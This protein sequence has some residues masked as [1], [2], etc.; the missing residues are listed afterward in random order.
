MKIAFILLCHKNSDQI[1]KLLKQLKKFDCEI[2]LHC[3]TK[4]KDIR[5]N[6]MKSNNVHI[7]SEQD[8]YD[9]KWGGTEMIF[10][11]LSL[12]KNVKKYSEN[13]NIK[14][15]YIW[16]LSGQDY[17]IQKPQFIIKK[18]QSNPQVNYLNI[19]P[20]NTKKYYEYLKR[21]EIK[22]SNPGWITKNTFIIKAIKYLYL[23]VTGGRFHTFK[24]FKRKKTFDGEFYFGSQWWTITDDCAN[25]ILKF[26]E[27]HEEYIEFFEN[28]IV[29]DECFF[30]TI[31]MN[32]CFKDSV[33]NNLT[34]VNWGNNNRSP[35]LITS[36]KLPE[37][38]KKNNEY[39]FARKFD[40]SV[41]S[42]ILDNVD[43]LLEKNTY[44]KKK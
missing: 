26:C 36:S 37:I 40:T 9:I 30:Q 41:E 27:E 20:S 39:F 29:P 16:L 31:I 35:D 22:Y 5:K 23:V 15:D 33:K 14:F 4:N 3:D 34:F 25:Y 19:T 42:N 17:I 24:I 2:F 7:L 12:L 21:C 32:S 38:I 8:S 6:I 43:E 44:K 13:N 10:A 18:L 11:T 1:N 28:T